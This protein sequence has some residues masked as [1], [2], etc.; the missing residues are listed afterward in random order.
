MG[1]QQMLDNIPKHMCAVTLSVLR[2]FNGMML[3]F[4][5]VYAVYCHYMWK[6][7]HC[8]FIFEWLTL[9]VKDTSASLS[10]PSSWMLSLSDLELPLDLFILRKYCPHRCRPASFFSLFSLARLFWNQTWWEKQARCHVCQGFW[11]FNRTDVGY[12]AQFA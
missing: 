6:H 8:V 7:L 1:T 12:L 9:P 10:M 3:F 2:H 11:Q 4:C 5:N